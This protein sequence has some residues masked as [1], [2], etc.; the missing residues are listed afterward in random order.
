MTVDPS[1]LPG[2][3]L[4]AAEL[5]A[6]AAVGYVVV[7]V[8]LRQTDERVALAQ[9]LVVGPAIWGLIVNSLL[10]AAPGFTAAA[11]GWGVMLALGMVLVWRAPDRI[12]PRLHVVAGF[13]G[14]V[15]VLCWV[16]LASRQLVGIPDSP[17]HLGLAAAIRAGDFPP[18]LP[19]NAGAPVRYHHGMDLLIGLLAPPMGPDLAF[20]TELLGAYVWTSFVLIVATA[21]LLRGSLFEVIVAAPL[22]LSSGLWTFTRVGAG[23]LQIPIPIAT[24]ETELVASLAEIYWPPAELS[25]RVSRA[26]LLPDIWKPAFP[27]GYALVI[28]ILDHAAKSD[29]WTWHSSAT[30]AGLV[31]FLSVLTPTLLPVVAVWAGLAAIQFARA[32]RAES[33]MRAALRSGTGLAL[34]G[35]LILVS[36]GMFARILVGAPA[37]GLVLAQSLHPKYWGALGTVALQPD[38]AVMLGVGPLAVACMAAILQRRDRLVLV[39]ATAAGVLVLTRMAL[40]YSPA[41]WD[42]DRLAG[43]GRNLALV[44]LLLAVTG[45]LASMASVRWRFAS[46]ALLVGLITWPTIVAPV[47]SLSLAIGNGIQLSNARSAHEET[48]DQGSALPA[49]RFQMPSLTRRVADYIL[50]HTPLDARVLATVGPHLNVVFA[51]GRPNNSGFVGLTHQFFQVGPEYLDA[52]RFLEPAALRKLGIEYVHVTDA[53]AAK[54]SAQAQAWLAD[55]QL[56][57]PLVSDEGERLY[58]VGTTLFSLDTPPNPTSFEALRRIVPPT[59]TVYL[60]VPPEDLNTLRVAS[61]LS[62][63]RLVGQLNSKHLH[64]LPPTSWHVKPLTDETPDLVVLPTGTVPWMFP[65]TARTP[66]WWRDNIAVYAPDGAVPRIMDVRLLGDSPLLGLPPVLME[67][68]DVTIANGRIEFKA[69]FDERSSQQWTSQD[70]IVLRVDQTPWAIPAEGYRRGTEPTIAKWFQGLLSAGGAST[71]HPYRFDARASELSVG[72]RDG[73]DFTPLPASAEQL[74][75]GGYTLALRLRHEFQPNHWRDAAVIPVMRIRISEE[76]GVSY[77]VFSDV[78]AERVPIPS[79]SSP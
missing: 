27:L 73:G 65:P 49:R 36:S 6:L 43:H 1:V 79:Y 75:P 67:I 52:A 71:W 42:L 74:A 72:G 17:I 62:H 45:R 16:G 58:R 55:P 30:L 29:R 14:A 38:G 9:G 15:V 31:G 3:L 19:W 63:T 32:R 2:L 40:T 21:L 23:L 68:S 57:E 53:S 35:L 78:L 77:E 13:V 39:L 64:L 47:R 20:V 22:L 26:E 60:V 34:A 11:V 69:V 33:G 12:C 76:G 44:A 24:P 10:Y 50:D 25:Q 18:G 8:A 37:S 28:V 61:A 56:F 46:G 66:I 48:L 5:S 54:L 7:R 70:W 59:T 51:T 4:L 41:P